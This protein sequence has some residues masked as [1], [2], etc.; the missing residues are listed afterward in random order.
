MRLVSP[1][2]PPH[3]RPV[4]VTGSVVGFSGYD[5]LVKQVIEA[6]HSFNVDVRINSA[7]DVKYDICPSY[8]KDI[9][10]VRPL[11]AWEIVIIPPCLLDSNGRS[12]GNKS[13]VFTMWETDHLEPD[14][15]KQLND[16]AFVVVPS[17]WA[18]DS[19][20]TSGVTVPIYKVPLGYDPVLFTSAGNYPRECVFGTA[21]ALA[22][23]GVRKNTSHVVDLFRQAFP[24]REKVKLKVKVMPNCPWNETNDRRVEVTKALL[25]TEQLAQWY[26]SISVFV[27]SSYAEGFGLHLIET[28]ASGRPIISTAYSAVTEYFDGTVGYVVDYQIVRA[29][30]GPY[31]GHWAKPVD[32]S[33][34]KQMRHVYNNRDE[35]HIKGCRAA[36]RAKAF[37]WKAMGQKLF[38]LLKG[39]GV[40]SEVVGADPRK[41]EARKAG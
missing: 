14:W 24:G 3:D 41:I 37:P 15:V 25:S 5:L 20:K 16:A 12:M 38:T 40:I 26:K 7:N 39:N 4:F 18:I 10:C 8:F 34:I 35:A 27:N 23:G 11:D 6:L 9:H 17:Q 13:V 28:M 29:T 33:I 21:A 32:E 31:T 1:G 30:G 19:F 2:A 22:G 36:I